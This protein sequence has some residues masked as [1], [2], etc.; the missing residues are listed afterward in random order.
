MP[1]QDV[2]SR[3]PSYIVNFMS[4]ALQCTIICLIVLILSP[5]WLW[6]ISTETFLFL[7]SISMSVRESIYSWAIL[8]RP[9]PGEMIIETD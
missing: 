7:S 1:T 8:G 6:H 5:Y 2:D 3:Q 4:D 9:I